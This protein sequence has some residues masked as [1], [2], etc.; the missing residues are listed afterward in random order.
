MGKELNESDFCSACIECGAK[1]TLD[2]E[3]CDDCD[4]DIWE[5]DNGEW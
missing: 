3:Y 2:E 1:I 4:P 5:D